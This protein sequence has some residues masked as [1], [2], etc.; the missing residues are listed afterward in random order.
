MRSQKPF[1]IG[2][3][4]LLALAAACAE[5]SDPGAQDGGRKGDGGSAS[6]ALTVD[7]LAAACIASTACRMLTYPKVSSCLENYYTLM[8]PQRLTG[9]WDKIYRCVN[10]AAGDCKAVEA[11]YD[12]RGDCDK[13]YRASCSGA[14]AVTCDLISGKAYA[15]DCSDAQM[16]CA[17]KPGY[18][19]QAVCTPGTCQTSLGNVCQQDVFINCVSGVSEAYD[20]GLFGM[21]CDVAKNSDG[22]LGESSQW[23]EA[24][25]FSPRCDGEKAVSCVGGREH[26]ED[27]SKRTLRDSK[28]SGGYCV[29]RGAACSGEM[30]RCSGKLLEACLDGVWK[31]FDC[32]QLGLKPCAD[33]GTYAICEPPDL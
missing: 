29:A 5:D 25:K 28:C 3:V 11:C 2:L 8:E 33:K 1:T 4:I 22:C 20:C 10:A 15:V 26:A 13:D 30:N 24:R 32:E 27:C 12:L 9:V 21:S 18:A 17:V 19:S 14:T 31:T 7:E 6:G 16:D 23:C